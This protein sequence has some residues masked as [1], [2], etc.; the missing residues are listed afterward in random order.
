MSPYPADLIVSQ[1]LHQRSFEGNDGRHGVSVISSSNGARSDSL[2]L[3]V[4]T[5]GGLDQQ[6]L[7]SFMQAQAAQMHN[8][9]HGQPAH[10]HNTHL[11]SQAAQ[12]QLQALQQQLFLQQLSA[13]AVSFLCPVYC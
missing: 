11:H 12:V 1:G 13:F 4:P 5:L 6:Q 3:N 7:A 8:A 10:V 2:H 9:F